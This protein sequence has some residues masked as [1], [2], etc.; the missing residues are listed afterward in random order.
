MVNRPMLPCGDRQSDI[1][2]QA[3]K[4]NVQDEPGEWKP[5]GKA[6]GFLNKNSAG[7]IFK[8]SLEADTSRFDVWQQS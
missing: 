8:D 1:I 3:A 6:E 5:G 2:F 7:H 4:Q